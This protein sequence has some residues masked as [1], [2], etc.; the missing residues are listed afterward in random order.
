MKPTRSPRGFT[1][2]E[3]LTVVAIIMIVIAL[4]LP[5]F[6]A[7]MKTQKWATTV[8]NLQVIVMRARALATNVRSSANGVRDSKD[9]S[10]EFNIKGIK[11]DNGTDMWIESES[12]T[13][14]RIPDLYTLEHQ[15][16]SGGAIAYLVF[17]V[18]YESGGSCSWGQNEA[19]CVVC[20][21]QWITTSTPTACPKCGATGWP[22]NPSYQTYY[23]NF[24]L[25]SK[26]YAES[27]GDNARQTD[28]VSLGPRMTI[29]LS[30]STNFVNWDGKT[31]VEY[32]GWDNTYDI[33]IGPHGALVQ[34]KDPVICLK[35]IDTGEVKKVKIVRCTG[36]VA[37]TR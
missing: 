29:D 19:R 37:P 23:Y 8:T 32:Y 24:K 14:E 6:I 11:G 10:V 3:M 26:P 18:W 28:C 35:H 34:T 1:L 30:R 22:N 36:R 25:T 5:N 7:I 4:A 20:G 9:F 31:S 33:R 2:I 15:L 12:N 17:G 27:Y 16:G 21:Y 13:L